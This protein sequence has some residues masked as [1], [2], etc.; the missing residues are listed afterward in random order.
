VKTVIEIWR[1]TFSLLKKHPVMV[2]PFCVTAAANLLSLWLVYLAPQRPVSYILAPPVRVFFGEKFL[3]YPLNFFI[4]PK[5]FGYAEIVVSA[6]VG[7]LMVALSIG[8]ISNAVKGEKTSLL[9]N[10][11][12]AIR[13]Y[14][15]LLGI[16]AINFIFIVLI[17]KI[18]LK[19]FS[20]T[21]LGR[22]LIQSVAYFF[23]VIFA[24]VLFIYVTPV[25]IIK[26][27]K[28]FPALKENFI[29]LKKIFFSTVALVVLP[30]FLYLPMVM[31][32]AKTIFLANKL[33][34]EIILAL[35]VIGALISVFIELV[36][37]VSTT[38]LFLR[39][40]EQR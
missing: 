34:P 22:G 2:Y 9:V 14:F 35:L 12:K 40:K 27:K 8:L 32:K 15:A 19:I 25:I 4:L 21:A 17:S 28:L 31:I 36:V 30:A 24:Q 39:T 20:A 10:F 13:R 3:H 11:N 1:E 16:W 6:L 38:L 5:L 29:I 33:F 26:K 7:I 23:L 37:T 18:I